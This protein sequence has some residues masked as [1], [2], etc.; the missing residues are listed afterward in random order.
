MNL[1]T[2]NIIAHVIIFHFY[3]IWDLNAFYEILLINEQLYFCVTQ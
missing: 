1:N 2:L 3:K